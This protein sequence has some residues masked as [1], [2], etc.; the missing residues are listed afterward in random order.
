MVFF[1]KMLNEVKIKP[2]LPSHPRITPLRFLATI[3][4]L[5]PV[6]LTSDMKAKVSYFL[7]VYGGILNISVSFG[8][9]YLEPS[10]PVKTFVSSVQRVQNILLPLSY[11]TTTLFM[12]IHMK[13]FLKFFSEILQLVQYMSA[14]AHLK[15]AMH[16]QIIV[17]IVGYTLYIIEV[18]VEYL[19]RKDSWDSTRIAIKALKFFLDTAML[20]VKL[21][22]FACLFHLRNLL[23]RVQSDL[24]KPNFINVNFLA[25]L[26]ERALSLGEIINQCFGVSIGVV[27]I[28]TTLNC[29]STAYF[30]IAQSGT[31]Y[32]LLLWIL[33]DVSQIW[34]VITSAV[35]FTYEVYISLYLL[36]L[37][38]YYLL[39]LFPRTKSASARKTIIVINS[40]S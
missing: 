11:I 33:I 14:W 15:Q 4:G 12:F 10:P 20:L 40:I 5:Y 19:V 38:N 34:M 1:C 23:C 16:I 3:Y 30:F 17:I 26:Y 8:R 18:V 35:L 31:D 21:Q 36:F 28:M 27:A 22:F 32:R 24:R 9:F 2:K 39:L 37:S 13:K 25:Q 6:V 7:V 29:I